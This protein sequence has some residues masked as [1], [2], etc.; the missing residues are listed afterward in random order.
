MP[1]YLSTFRNLNLYSWLIIFA[2]ICANFAMQDYYSGKLSLEGFFFGLPVI[3]GIVYWSEY[4]ARLIKKSEHHLKKK[5]LFFRD[6]FL[7][8]Y[9]CLLGDILSLIFQYNNS[10]ARA[11][12]TLALYFSSACNLMF[13]FIFSLIALMLNSHRLYTAIF[14][15]LML[16]IFTCSKFWPYYLSLSVIGKT[17][18]F[19]VILCFLIIVHLLFSITYKLTQVFQLKLP[20]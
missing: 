3:G 12:W 15:F 20:K 11:W 7:I 4:S 10:D 14:S 9:S 19:L 5:D 13:A 1:N 6:F 8:S 17:N 16:V 2:Y 18:T